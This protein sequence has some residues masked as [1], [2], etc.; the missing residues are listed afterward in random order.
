MLL[1]AHHSIAILNWENPAHNPVTKAIDMSPD[2]KN[3][4]QYSSVIVVQS[5][6][7]K[8]KVFVNMRSDV[9]FGSI[10]KND[11]IWSS[12]TKKVYVRT[13]NASQSR[14]VNI[15]WIIF[16]NLEYA[17]QAL[18]T[19]DLQRRMG[20]D[21]VELELIPHSI[22]HTMAEGTKISIKALKVRVI[23]DSRQE[24]FNSLLTCLKRGNDDDRLDTMSN[25]AE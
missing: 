15:E 10:K 21:T 19:R 22:F 1:S 2:E 17:N 11:R 8:I 9:S 12:L 16:S 5:N 14:H 20:I 18:A 25:M 13:T 4:S 3:I 24:I 7:Q 23:Y 6:R